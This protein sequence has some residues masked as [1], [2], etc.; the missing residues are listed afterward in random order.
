MAKSVKNR[1][2]SSLSIPRVSLK[3][4][5]EDLDRAEE[6]IFLPANEKEEEG[7]GNSRESEGGESS[8]GEE[9]Q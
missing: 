1:R 2:S 3:R 4:I 6:N 8:R 9:E 5:E 7:E